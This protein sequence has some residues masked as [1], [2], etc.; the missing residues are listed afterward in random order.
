[1]IKANLEKVLANLGSRANNVL[2]LPAVKGR[3]ESDF[4]RLRELGL[5]TVGENRVQE[6]LK[7]YEVATDFKWHFIGQLQSNKVKYVVG[8]CELIHSLDR[9]SLAAEINRVSQNRGL[10]TDCLIELNV[11]NEPNKGGLAFGTEHID[12]FLKEIS[13]FKNIKIRGLMTVMPNINKSELEKLYDELGKLF[14]HYKKQNGWD[15][16]SAGMSDDYMLAVKYG[17]NLIRLGRV[18]FN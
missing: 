5:T 15:I 1:V 7:H 6:F 18:L 10:V 8:K 17:A 13:E 11:A 14:A 2:I 4:A 3:N 9:F 16:L 12:K